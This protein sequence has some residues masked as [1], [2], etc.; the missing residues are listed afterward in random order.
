MYST[1]LPALL[2][3]ADCSQRG[4]W[5]LK[6]PKIQVLLP[7]NSDSTDTLDILAPTWIIQ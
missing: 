7:D 2:L 1:P 5:A 6:S 4:L 3:P